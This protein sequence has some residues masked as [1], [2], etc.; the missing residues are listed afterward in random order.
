MR[1]VSYASR[2]VKALLL[3]EIPLV[4]SSLRRHAHNYLMS[5]KVQ[6]PFPGSHPILKKIEENSRLILGKEANLIPDLPAQISL[7]SSDQSLSM[8]VALQILDTGT[9]Q[10]LQATGNLDAIPNPQVIPSAQPKPLSPLPDRMAALFDDFEP[11]PIPDV[12]ALFDGLGPMNVGMEDMLPS[13]TA[14]MQNQPTQ[15]S[16]SVVPALASSASASTNAALNTDKSLH[17]SVKKPIYQTLANT[18]FSKV[19]S[20]NKS[21]TCSFKAALTADQE[22]T[23]KSYFLKHGATTKHIIA[24]AYVSHE[25]FMNHRTAQGL[26]NKLKIPHLPSGSIIFS[27]SMYPEVKKSLEMAGKLSTLQTTVHLHQEFGVWYDQRS[28]YHLKRIVG[29]QKAPPI[30]LKV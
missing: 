5:R 2:T 7:N 10:S 1:N 30:E 23:M 9:G 16:E 6:P 27:H 8:Q 24:Y 14:L 28:I 20:L 18:Y 29:L 15:D 22:N 11:P 19:A 26:L 25:I 12:S 13:A 21:P 3:A 17:E 4:R